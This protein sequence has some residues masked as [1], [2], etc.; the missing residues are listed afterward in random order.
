MKHMHFRIAS[1]LNTDCYTNNVKTYII[2]HRLHNLIPSMLYIKYVDLGLY[3]SSVY[4]P[5]SYLEMCREFF[6]PNIRLQFY[7][8]GC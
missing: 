8:G 3:T 7:G 2:N 5:K 4:Y 1:F 6:L